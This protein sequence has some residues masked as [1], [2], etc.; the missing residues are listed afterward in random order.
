MTR[1]QCK[2]QYVQE[3]GVIFARWI[4]FSPTGEN[5]AAYRKQNILCVFFFPKNA[6]KAERLSVCILSE[7][8]K[9]TKQVNLGRDVCFCHSCVLEWR[10]TRWAVQWL[11]SSWSGDLGGALSFHPIPR[12]CLPVQG[13]ISCPKPSTA[14]LLSW[15]P[16]LTLPY[17][18]EWQQSQLLTLVR[19]LFLHVLL[20]SKT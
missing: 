8:K 11:T 3:Q 6:I 20:P 19:L 16:L 12:P 10:W 5:T 7:R 17:Y 2:C 18:K 4:F 9:R 15:L 1:K 13:A 14:R